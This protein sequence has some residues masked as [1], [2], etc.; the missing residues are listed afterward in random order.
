MIPSAGGRRAPRGRGAGHGPGRE[1]GVKICGCRTPEDA[2]IAVEAG[3]THVGVVFAGGPRR[4][5]LGEAA[6]IVAAAGQARGVGV[7]VDA[8]PEEVLEAARASG[9]E[10]AQLH[11]REPPESCAALREAGIEVWKAL[12]PRSAAELEADVERYRDA[13]DAVLVEGFSPAAAGGTGT[14]F[15]LAWLDSVRERLAEGGPDLVLAGGLTPENVTQ[16]IRR[17]GPA[18]VDVSSGVER[19]PGEKDPERVRAFVQAARA[20]R[21]RTPRAR[22]GRDAAGGTPRG[23]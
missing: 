10:V 23:S 2:R 6:G 18:I 13:V 11:G 17:A 19:R 14:G 20:G 3:A 1:P 5:T 7:F 15:P 16:A 21:R 4:V 12:R 9:V 8:S 22:Q